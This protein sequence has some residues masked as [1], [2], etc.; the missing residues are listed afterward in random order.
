MIPLVLEFET[1]MTVDEMRSSLR[2]LFKLEA[3]DRSLTYPEYDLAAEG[4][5]S[6]IKD[7]YE[8]LVGLIENVEEER[9]ASVYRRCT[10]RILHL[11]GRVNRIPM[12]ATQ[13]KETLQ[14]RSKWLGKVSALLSRVEGGKQPV[15]A[16]TPNLSVIARSSHPVVQEDLSEESDSSPV[17][18]G[19]ATGFKFPRT[20]KPQPVEK[21]GLK[22]SGDPKGT[23]V[24]SF[25]ERVD[26]LRKARHVSE[27]ELFASALDLF[28]GKALLWYRSVVTRCASWTE[29]SELL[30]K[31]FLPPDYRPRLFQEILARVQG[32][33]EPFIE[34]F[35]CMTTLFSRYGDIPLDIQLDILVRNL[36]PFYTM[37]LPTVKSLRELEEECL[38]LETRKYRADHY[39]APSRKSHL[40]SVEPEL[41]CVVTPG[42]SEARVSNSRSGSNTG[43]VNCWNCLKTGHLVRFCDRPLRKHCFSCGQLDVTTRECRRC[44]PRSKNE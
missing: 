42:V 44:N 41:S 26:E 16:S 2:S 20:S 10:S 12:G 9:R 3:T 17:E 15:K 19:G 32:P 18:S 7:K 1:E 14:S 6:T 8:E 39:Q 34:Y 22:F 5:L 40:A 29:L 35:S 4:E 21:W 27:R 25:L 24:M 31:H 36:A 11:I 33:S 13:S 38:Q 28:E 43:D 30:R 37:Q 23:S